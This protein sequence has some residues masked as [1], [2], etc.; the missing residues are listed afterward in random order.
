MG[1]ACQPHGGAPLVKTFAVG[2]AFTRQE[3]PRP[4]KEMVQRHYES[5]YPGVQDRTQR[6]RGVH[7]WSATLTNRNPW[8]LLSPSRML[9]AGSKPLSKINAC[10]DVCCREI[11]CTARQ[12]KGVHISGRKTL[13]HVLFFKALLKVPTSNS[14]YPFDLGWYG[15]VVILI[16]L[17][18][19]WIVYRYPTM[20]TGMTY[21]ANSWCKN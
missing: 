6:T 20:A 5:Q 16:L 3:K 12:T 17:N 21:L 14:A 15:G 1:G 4:S 8:L 11:S 7:Q 18:N 13:C 2:R 9:N 19:Q 10:Q